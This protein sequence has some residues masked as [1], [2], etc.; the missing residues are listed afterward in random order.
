M[1]NNSGGGRG[2]S[3]PGSGRKPK[4][5][6]Q[7]DKRLMV[8]LTADQWAKLLVAA[9]ASGLAP[10]ELVRKWTTDILVNCN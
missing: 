1:V 7:A 8:R 9:N 5:S 10:S 2:G 4:H 6:Q 3:R